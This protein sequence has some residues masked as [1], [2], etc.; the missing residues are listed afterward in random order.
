MFLTY[1]DRSYLPLYAFLWVMFGFGA[2]ALLTS[3]LLLSEFEPYLPVVDECGDFI[4]KR[5]GTPLMPGEELDEEDEDLLADAMGDMGM[6]EE[7]VL[8]EMRKLGM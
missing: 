8:E 7:E 2:I 5:D 6:T 3:Y 4:L 1:S